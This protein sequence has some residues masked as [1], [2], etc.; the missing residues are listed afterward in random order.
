MG[1]IIRTLSA[2]AVCLLL[3]GETATAEDLR[4]LD[5][6]Q[7]DDKGKVRSL[8]TEKADVNARQADGAT[9]LSWA[10]YNDDFDLAELLL[11]AGANVN[12]ANDYGI[13]PLNLACANGSASMVERLLKA[14]AAPNDSEFMS[15]VRT[16][17]LAAVQAMLAH[18]ANA[19]ARE[20]REEQTALMWAA[21]ERHTESWKLWLSIA[22]M[23]R[24]T[25]RVDLRR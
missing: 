4:L 2:F 7:K 25:R 11:E 15:C 19:N 13:T 17:N 20:D 6:T 9:P 21:A 3:A 12:A 8:L 14:G 23:F 5:A 16:G 1:I 10:A 18:R 22:P 24:P